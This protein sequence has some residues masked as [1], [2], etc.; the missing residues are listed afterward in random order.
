M[1]RPNFSSWLKRPT[2]VVT[3]IGTHFVVP[4]LSEMSSAMSL[5]GLKCQSPAL[6]N[7]GN[8][9]SGTTEVR[10]SVVIVPPMFVR[11]KARCPG[12]GP[13]CSGAGRGQP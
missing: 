11:D 6:R 3:V 9:N 2:P 13:V 10:L 7:S 4:T 1:V 8:R 12:R 5:S